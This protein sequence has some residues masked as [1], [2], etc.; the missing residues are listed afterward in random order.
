MSHDCIQVHACQQLDL[1]RA[2]YVLYGVKHID[3]VSLQLL[4]A[5]GSHLDLGRAPYVL[6][7]VKHVGL[8]SLQ[9]PN[10]S[11]SHLDLGRAPMFCMSLNALT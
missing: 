8:V 2:P 1:I 4:N 5:S 3:L 6:H 10:A 7:V 9:L 11:G